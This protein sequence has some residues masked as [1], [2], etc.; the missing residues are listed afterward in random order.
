MW[1][2]VI[3]GRI[4]KDALK[5]K[6]GIKAC[7]LPQAL[8]GKL[9][10][11]FTMGKMPSS[12]QRNYAQWCQRSF[13]PSSDKINT[14]NSSGDN[15][16]ISSNSGS[17]RASKAEVIAKDSEEIGSNHLND[18][19]DQKSNIISDE[20]IV[21]ML[22]PHIF[23]CVYS[24]TRFLSHEGKQLPTASRVLLCLEAWCKTKGSQLCPIL[25]VF[26]CIALNYLLDYEVFAI[27][28]YLLQE[29][30]FLTTRR[31]SWAQLY[32][33][34]RVARQCTL[35]E[36][37]TLCKNYIIP[38]SEPQAIPLN[39]DHPL[40]GS[41]LSW[42]CEDLP[43]FIVERFFDLFFYEGVKA[44]YRVGLAIIETWYLTEKENGAHLARS[45][46]GIRYVRQIRWR[47]P[48]GKIDLGE[49]LKKGASQRLGSLSSSRNNSVN[50]DPNSTCPGDI[51]TTTTTTT[52]T[53]TTTTTTQLRNPH[54]QG[55]MTWDSVDDESNNHD[56]DDDVDSNCADFVDDVFTYNYL[57]HTHA[58]QALSIIAHNIAHA[59]S[60][61]TLAHSFKFKTSQL[62]QYETIGRSK[63]VGVMT[64]DGRERFVDETD[65]SLEQFHGCIRLPLVPRGISPSSILTEK[66][67]K[68]M[69]PFCP[70]RI[71]PSRANVM[72][73]TLDH[74]YSLQRLYSECGKTCPILLA[75]RTK[76]GHVIGAFLTQSIESSLSIDGYVGTGEMFL[77]S[78][79][80][81]VDDA[82]MG[83]NDLCVFPWAGTRA[84]NKAARACNLPQKFFSCS[85]E[86]MCIGAGHNG[87]AIQINSDL[88]GSTS[89]S[90]TFLSPPLLP[91][92]MFSCDVAEIWEFIA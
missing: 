14:G 45:A 80:A 17:K 84:S 27:A 31:S 18:G 26:V 1:E 44:F 2:E 91:Q 41:V 32:A 75:I 89:A 6:K 90:D 66:H 8:R 11:R 39:E 81:Q 88:N 55:R 68:T 65:V 24:F 56:H 37:K 52:M 51:A 40:M 13:Q 83:E 92:E 74:G 48:M 53:T 64:M 10:I 63:A 34:S 21:H 3:E 30:L 62:L 77:F 22:G 12:A 25:P 42:I 73:S 86:V 70:A 67:W 54:Q 33:F 79:G 61:F 47:K 46:T 36:Y 72:Y 69:W 57:C 43:T 85:L 23:G 82:D 50:N 7:L 20:E 35:D 16:K 76:C 71:R 58:Q 49:H 29:D 9:W 5:V 19:Y 38:T 15:N 4:S 59:Q 78:T 60:F 28:C 87:H